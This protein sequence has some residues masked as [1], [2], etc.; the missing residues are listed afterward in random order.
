MRSTKKYTSLFQ[1]RFLKSFFSS[2]IVIQNSVLI[3]KHLIEEKS[4]LDVDFLKKMSIIDSER[5]KGENF[6]A[7]TIQF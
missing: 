6:N 3:F 1:M 2:I 5:E 7:V 4:Q